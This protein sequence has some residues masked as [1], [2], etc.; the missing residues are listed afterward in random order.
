MQLLHQLEQRAADTE[1]RLRQCQNAQQRSRARL[2]RIM[3]KAEV[4]LRGP[5]PPSEQERE[6]WKAFQDLQVEFSQPSKF[7]ARVT[8][9]ESLQ[10]MRSAAPSAAR[11]PLALPDNVERAVVD[12]LRLQRDGL[13]KLMNVLKK[14]RR[15]L[16]LM[17]D[18]LGQLEE[19][20]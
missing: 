1:A 9:L 2:I 14:D 17:Q 20:S 16:Q 5:S 12:G 18:M 3:R 6:V 4:A 13:E 7:Q 8:E 11:E 10:R 15:D 19:R